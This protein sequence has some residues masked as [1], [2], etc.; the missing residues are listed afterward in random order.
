[1]LKRV[2]G[3]TDPFFYEKIMAKTRKQKEE[4]LKRLKESLKAM[5]ALVFVNYDGVGVNE[6][7]ELRKVLRENKVDYYVAKRTLL[8]RAFEEN[9]MDIDIGSLSGGL[10]LAFG[11]EDEVMPAKLL[12]DFSKEHE[13][14][15]LIGGIFEGN[16]IDK[17]KVLELAK[18][19]SRE[20]LIFKTVYLIKSPVSGLVNVLKGNLNKLVFVLKAI[21]EKG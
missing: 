11:L 16:F 1:V 13:N 2:C 20:E 6:I 3:N 17:E 10:G 4:E 8:K 12:Y 7:N 5:K 18:L 21:Q 19:P 14:L 15:K 9:K